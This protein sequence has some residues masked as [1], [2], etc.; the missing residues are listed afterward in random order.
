MRSENPPKKSSEAA[1]IVSPVCAAADL[2]CAG[3]CRVLDHLSS[4]QVQ[5]N[6]HTKCTCGKGHRRGRQRREDVAPAGHKA[7]ETGFLFFAFFN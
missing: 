5:R 4:G 1:G 7:D 3:L 2:L 6:P